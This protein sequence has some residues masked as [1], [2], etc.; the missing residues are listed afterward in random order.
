MSD[1]FWNDLDAVLSATDDME[2]DEAL[3][4]LIRFLEEYRLTA[5]IDDGVNDDIPL[6]A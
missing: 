1:Q 4:T 5:G 6:G 3:T 2:A